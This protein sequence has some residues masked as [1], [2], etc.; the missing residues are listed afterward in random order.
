MFSSDIAVKE[1]RDL[2]QYKNKAEQD[3]G[4][5]GPSPCP[6]REKEKNKVQWRQYDSQ[7]G[8]FIR[9]IHGK[10]GIG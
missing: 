9:K 3:R 1:V 7:N 10:E 2:D 5:K 6:L 8:E 4:N